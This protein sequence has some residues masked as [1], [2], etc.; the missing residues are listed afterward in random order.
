MDGV[1]GFAQ[2]S[3]FSFFSKVVSHHHLPPL[4]SPLSLS[5]LPNLMAQSNGQA[6][7]RHIHGEGLPH[8]HFLFTSESVGEGHPGAA[9]ISIKNLVVLNIPHRQDLRS[10]LRRYREEQYFN[11]SSEIFMLVVARCRPS[12]RSVLQGRLRD[13]IQDWHDHGLRR[14][15]LQGCY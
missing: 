7:G 10:S 3:P 6:L 13:R 5:F 1:I 9:T 4:R 11:S 12:A 15:H 2:V 8:N 14:N